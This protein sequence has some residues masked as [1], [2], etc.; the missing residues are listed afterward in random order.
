MAIMKKY[1]SA[2]DEGLALIGFRLDPD[3]D[4]P[5]VYT[6]IV[7]GGKDRPILVQDR[8][9]LFSSPEL[10]FHAYELGD[11]N[12]KRLGPPPSSPSLVCDV[13]EMLDIIGNRNTDESSVILNCINTMLDLL[14]P[15]KTPIPPGYKQLLFSF[16]DHLTFDREF[17]SFL[18]RNNIEREKIISAITWCVGA[19]VVRARFLST[20][21]RGSDRSRSS[22][23]TEA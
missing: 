5:E 1:S 14:D 12:V 7:Y 18:N 21:E 9:V 17:A 6:L 3:R 8:I 13:A 15:G 19:I 2:D 22:E 11:A 23:Q 10:V 16:A 4:N 20:R